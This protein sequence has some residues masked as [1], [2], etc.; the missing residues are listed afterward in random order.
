M[1]D[2]KVLIVEDDKKIADLLNDYLTMSGFNVSVLN[3]GDGVVAEIKKNVPDLIILDI[4]LPGKDGITLCT[5]I[6]SFSKVPI[7]FCSAK[8]EEIDR[9]LGLEIGAD[10]Y[11]C[12][13][14]SPR[15]VV[16]RVK[17]VLR[18]LA[19]NQDE[20]M[21]VIGP[22][23]IKQDSHNAAIFGKQL[24]LTP[25]EFELLKILTIYPHKVFNRSDLMSNFKRYDP[26][27]N[28]RTIDSHMKNLRKKIEEVS[29]GANVIRTVYG[30]GYSLNVST[31][32]P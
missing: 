14:F 28:I 9:V 32:A 21:L 13:P 19:D 6:R 24:N 8:I 27:C 17:A 5:E 2:K 12:K 22:I 10:D 31:D 3:R 29:P 16:V 4:M 7:M 18:R 15:E 30:T 25:N 1:E 20:R 23:I 11:I 26:K